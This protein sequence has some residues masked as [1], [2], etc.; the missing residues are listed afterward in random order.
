MASW[1]GS[2]RRSRLGSLIVLGVLAGLTA[3][4]AVAS[5]DGAQRTGTAQ[6]RLR[7]RTKASDALVFASQALEPQLHPDWAPLAARPEVKRLARWG[8]AFGTVDHNVD[9]VLF[10]P[11][12]HVWF[13]EVDRPIV[14]AGR[15]FDPAAADEAVITD[16]GNY[17]PE[18]HLGGTFPF[19]AMGVDQNFGDVPNG[20]SID[21]RIVGVVHTPLPSAFT[22]GAYL[23][24]GFISRYG[25]QSYVAENA[26]VQ[27]VHGAGDIA[28]LREDANVEL[29]SPILDF[30]VVGRR[31][32][33]TTDVERAM[34]LLLALIVAAAGL[35][36]I[37]QALA[38]S[39]ATI[40]SDEQTLRA[41]GM[42]RDQLVAA[43][44]RPHVITAGVALVVTAAT[45]TIASRWFP[46]GLAARIDPDRGIRVNLAL[47]ACAAV[48]VCALIIGGAAVFSWLAVRDVARRPERPTWLTRL[49]LLKPLNIGIGAR[50][51]LDGGGR[52]GRGASRPALV[53]AAAAVAGIVAIVTLNHGL[54]ESL[55]HPEVAG[56]AWDASVYP[57]Y[58]D[59]SAD[60]V[61]PAVLASVQGTP[62]VAA[63]ATVHRQIVQLG[64]VG[65]PT[66]GLVDV[67][68]AH[69]MR[70]V[71]LEG[72]GPEH[73]GE[74]ALGPS[75]AH[76]LGVV[77]GDNVTMGPGR[78][79]RVVG[80]GLF[81][82]DVHSQF[83]E[84]AWVA[85]DDW[86]A[87]AG[88][89]SD[90]GIEQMVAV[91]F[92]DRHDIVGQVD[93]LSAALGQ[94]VLGVTVTDRPEELSNL[95]NVKAL[96]TVLATFLTVLGVVAVGHVLF[97]SVRRRRRDFAVLRA[98]GVTRGGVRG[99]LSAHG[100][101]VAIVGLIVGIPIGLA[102][103]RTGWQAITDRVPLVFH[104]PLTAGALMVVVPLAIVAANA[105]AIVPGRR[106]ARLQPATI[107]RSE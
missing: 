43:A 75:T 18:I 82:A 25:A 14:V 30:H 13:S 42:S 62:G 60:G 105:L 8:L 1:S 3:G 4:L 19:A 36:F 35:V 80:L 83:D 12:D 72:R 98:L 38:R 91:Q 23:S 55:S 46:V 45:E 32:T 69:P 76:D 56:V 95:H 27:L 28:Q 31:V 41:M 101:T 66:F 29:A 93:A 22:D 100:C 70:L 85:F 68:A 87:L 39:A 47:F 17:P 63:V 6:T 51:A 89:A 97:S 10:V 77:I 102:A 99:I 67:Q 92:T 40:N 103:G 11:M 78:A 16:D 106:A 44:V 84:G 7:E 65:V 34:L 94:T 96:P 53:G 48:S 79:L 81:P 2:D 104:S 26:A 88:G 86:T 90:S 71:T 9:D 52:H 50:M 20:P 57:N 74:V 24:P 107:L 58:S 21:V 64:D 49:G 54:D 73:S 33:A 59:M 61:A 15:M 5:F 37:G